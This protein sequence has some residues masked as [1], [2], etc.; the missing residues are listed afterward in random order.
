[1]SEK[2]EKWEDFKK[3]GKIEDYLKY[4]QAEENDSL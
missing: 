3:T 4:K 1:M 2:K